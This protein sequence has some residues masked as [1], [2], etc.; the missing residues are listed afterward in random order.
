MQLQAKKLHP[1][2]LSEFVFIAADFSDFKNL[3]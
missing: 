1:M 3:H 2:Q